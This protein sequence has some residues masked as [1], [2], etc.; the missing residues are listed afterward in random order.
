MTSSTVCAGRGSGRLALLA[1]RRLREA[2]RSNLEDWARVALASNGHGPAA[3]HRLM[4]S[5]LERVARGE[6]DRLMLLL[7]PGSAKSTYASVLFPAW[8][9][10]RHPSSSVIATSHTAALARH[11][12]R[13]VRGLL[14]E[15][16]ARLGVSLSRDLRGADRFATQAG[17]QYFSTGV[18]GAVTGRR[19]D[20]VLVD[21]PVRSHAE[22]DS[23]AARDRLW[24]WFR[25]DLVT[26]LR[27]GGRIVLV[28]TRWHP[29]DLA[30]RL[31]EADESWRVVRLPALA[32]AGDVLGRAEG[33][34]LWPDWE[35]EAAL[36][37]K[38]RM[39]GERAFA[40]LFQQAPTRAEGRLF[41]PGRMAVLDHVAEA[42][43]SQVVRAWD[44]AATAA[45][46]RDPDWTVGV[47]LMRDAE[48]RFVVLDVVRLRGGPAQV[49]AAIRSTAMADG[50]GVTIGLPQDPD[51]PGE[52]RS[53]I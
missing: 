52:R 29:D 28:M 48:G 46:G 49:E 22:A 50:A 26:R 20:L 43:G 39:L 24:C 11:F 33:A 21:D 30:G 12:G 31:L 35:D 37:R 14:E 51:R 19:A 45:E 5:E 4:M 41:R 1:E 9:L 32:E 53:R 44:L 27:P 40:A 38:R 10:A 7:P 18:R 2:V 15:H 8:W 6:D 25:S 42:A 23:A 16:G 13:G 3:H 34:A 36:A 17:G 47:K